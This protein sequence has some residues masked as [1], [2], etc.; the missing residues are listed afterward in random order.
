MTLEDIKE[1]LGVEK[2]YGHKLTPTRK[3]KLQ[4]WELGWVAERITNQAIEEMMPFLKGISETDRANTHSNNPHDLWNETFDM[5][6]K[7]SRKPGN[8]KQVKKQRVFLI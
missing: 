5:L 2:T 6:V 8:N 1:V 7:W 3:P 4:Y